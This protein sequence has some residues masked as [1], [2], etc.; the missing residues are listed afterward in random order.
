[1]M[2]TAP[3]VSI[4]LPAAAVVRCP[5]PIMETLFEAILPAGFG[6]SRLTSS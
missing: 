6:L 3:D 5:C 1:M 4:N 2:V